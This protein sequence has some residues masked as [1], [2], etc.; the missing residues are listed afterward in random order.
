M[1]FNFSDIEKYMVGNFCHSLGD[2]SLRTYTSVNNTNI[3]S[4]AHKCIIH[5]T[6][7]IWSAKKIQPMTDSDPLSLN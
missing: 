7:I 6:R 5:N 4:K 1:T 3:H 2:H